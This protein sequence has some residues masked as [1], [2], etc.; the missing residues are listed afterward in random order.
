LTLC[1]LRSVVKGR[2]ERPPSCSA[3]ALA[4]MGS[5]SSWGCFSPTG[6]RKAAGTVSSRG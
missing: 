6:R 4:P 3:S 5:E 2:C 1:G